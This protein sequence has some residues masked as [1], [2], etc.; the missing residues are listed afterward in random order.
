MMD[1]RSDIAIVNAL[2]SATI[3]TETT[4]TGVTVDRTG[5]ESV[6][7]AVKVEAWTDGN[8]TLK[9]Q[10]SANGSTWADVASDFVI[11]TATALTAV[12]IDTLGYVGEKQYCRLAVVSVNETAA[13]NSVLSGVAVKGHA[14]HQPATS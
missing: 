13:V 1:L 2:T 11:G 14:R 6:T 7:F 3:S 9:L 4:T 5:F 12:G 8:F 10:D